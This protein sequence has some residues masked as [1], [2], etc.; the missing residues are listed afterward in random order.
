M[1]RIHL[2]DQLKDLDPYH[3]MFRRRSCKGLVEENS[4]SNLS[5]N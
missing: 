3:L 4:L 1:L 5:C 2:N